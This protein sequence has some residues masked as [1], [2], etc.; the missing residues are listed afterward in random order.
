VLTNLLLNAQEATRS[1]AGGSGGRIRL[2]TRHQGDWALL[3]VIDDG[4]GMTPDFLTRHLFQP[5]RSTK[6]GGLGI[7]LYQCRKIVTAHGGQI[8]VESR[9]GKGT[10]VTIS[11]PTRAG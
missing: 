9:A 4:C 7:G 8:T 10:T 5:F 11:L 1:A 2:R 6:P 3:S